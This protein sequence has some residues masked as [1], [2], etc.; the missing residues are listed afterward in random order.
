MLCCCGLE[1]EQQPTR[2]IHAAVDV[3]ICMRGSAFSSAV[4]PGPPAYD[5]L[6]CRARVARA[7]LTV[8]KASAVI[9]IQRQLAQERI[10]APIGVL[11]L[12]SGMLN[13]M[14]QDGVFDAAL[15]DPAAPAPVLP[16]NPRHDPQAVQTALRWVMGMCTMLPLDVHACAEVLRCV[17]VEPPPCPVMLQSARDA[18]VALWWCLWAAPRL[19]AGCSAASGQAHATLQAPVSLVRLCRGMLSSTFRSESLCSHR[20]ACMIVSRFRLKAEWPF[21]IVFAA[22]RGAGALSEPCWLCCWDTSPVR[23]FEA[24]R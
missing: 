3:V 4:Q 2:S 24:H 5:A 9:C 13:D 8:S 22:G 14:V 23:C 6:A 20:E 17:A 1:W 21:V 10:S 12:Y 7:V 11:Q 18:T 15:D 19:H 16:V